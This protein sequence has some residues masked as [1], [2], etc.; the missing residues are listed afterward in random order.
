MPTIT[1]SNSFIQSG[2]KTGGNQFLCPNELM[3]L[4]EIIINKIQKEGPI[5]FCDYMEM[6]LYYPELGYYNS[7]RNKIGKDGDFLTSPTISPLFGEL[8]AKQIEEM[9]SLLGENPFTIIEY[10]AGTGALCEAILNYLK[11]N[12]KLYEGLEYCII[13][14]SEWLRS[15][16]QLRFSE[17]V[18]WVDSIRTIPKIN[19]CVISNELVD[20]FA[21]HRVAMNE[22]LNEVF[23]DYKNGFIEILKPARQELVDY[24]T[25]LKVELC[26][27]FHAEINLEA[28]NWISEIAGCLNKGYVITIDYGYPSFELYEDYRKN[29]TLMCFNKHKANSHPYRAIGEQDI[30]SHVNFS[31]ICLWG[32]KNGLDYC[33]FTDQDKFLLA[34]GFMNSLRQKRLPGQDSLNFKKEMFLTQLL[35]QE[36]GSKFKVLIQQKGVPK[37]NLMGLK[38]PAALNA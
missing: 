35:L 26:K 6:C 14:K 38:S 3:K 37:Y 36:M 21:V 18:K 28:I 32:F 16:Q 17:K 7:N 29:G 22:Q 9:W 1:Q 2:Y 31:A 5:S 30:T 33:G 25:E 20:N 12:K 4:S 11:C 27:G 13:E 15:I 24:L 8:I 23:V 10:G 34:L 19:G